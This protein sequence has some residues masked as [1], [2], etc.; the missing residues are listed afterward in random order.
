[1]S[2]Y[3]SLP[4]RNPSKA[5]RAFDAEKRKSN[6]TRRNPAVINANEDSGLA[7][8]SWKDRR[9]APRMAV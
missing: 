8:T 1:M 2:H 7:N 9:N 5:E 3:P 6:A 4:F